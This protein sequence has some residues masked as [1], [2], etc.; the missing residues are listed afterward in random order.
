MPQQAT[1]GEAIGRFFG[2]FRASTPSFGSELAA[3][4]RLC[5]STAL[6]LLPMPSLTRSEDFFKS[7][8][9]SVQGW[10][11]AGLSRERF[12]TLLQNDSSTPSQGS[13]LLTDVG[14][15]V[16]MRLIGCTERAVS[17][18][19]MPLHELPRSTYRLSEEGFTS[20]TVHKL[21]IAPLAF[22][23]RQ[24]RGGCVWRR[25]LR[26]ACDKHM[27][28]DQ[29][30]W[31]HLACSKA[32]EK[33]HNAI[34]NDNAEECQRLGEWTLRRASGISALDPSAQFDVVNQ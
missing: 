2:M 8:K 19:Q 18:A 25:G 13:P 21:G 23:P 10:L 28:V 29:H 22:A 15:Q 12:N 11:T 7:S 30:S 14:E 3:D 9:H 34:R 24:A 17:E 31:H 5:I 4:L 16:K 26:C 33:L 20:V 1:C 27:R 6:A 32:S